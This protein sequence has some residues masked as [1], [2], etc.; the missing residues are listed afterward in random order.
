MVKVFAASVVFVFTLAFNAKGTFGSCGDN[1]VVATRIVGGEDAVKHS[2]PW[3]AALVSSNPNSLFYNR[4]FCGGTI[5]D[6]THILTAAHCTG[7]NSPQSINV[8]TGEHDTTVAQGEIRHSVKSIVNHP[9]YGSQTG[10]DFDFSILTIDCDEEID[11]SDKARAACLPE[12]DVYEASGATFNV[13]GWGTLQS[14]GGSPD[15][16][17]VVTVPFISD[18]VCQ[19]KYSNPRPGYS[20]ATITD[21]MICAGNA[22]EGGIDSCQGDSGGPLTWRDSQGKWNII[23]VV[24]W[25]YG[26]A[27]V[28]HPGV[29]A[30]VVKVLDWVKSNSQPGG[31]EQCD[32]SNPTPTPSSP[33][34]ST[35][36]P[37][38]DAPTTGTTTDGSIADDCV[39]EWIG[40]DY[41]D[42]GNNNEEC[43]WDGG[44]CCQGEDAPDGWDIY[45][46]ECQCLDEPCENNWSTWFCERVKRWGLCTRNWA[47]ENCK[48]TCDQCSD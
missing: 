14:G 23:G 30:E 38:S 2:I 45:C 22:A 10:I 18:S 8:L 47:K 3:Q 42:D 19:Q 13:S 26:C 7:S 39:T 17:N 40:D 37:T 32:G 48:Q 6:S 5:I 46:S 43:Q 44:D 33:A 25:G 9:S 1:D 16:L 24:S 29:Y 15:I 35:E 36:G 34:P 27:D 4:P 31:N 21:E 11:L 20:P 28:R 12:S 41:C